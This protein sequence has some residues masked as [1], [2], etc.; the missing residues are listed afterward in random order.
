LP[1]TLRGAVEALIEHVQAPPSLCAHSVLSAA[2]LA[3]QGLA[4]V[5]IPNIP[6][7]RPLSLFML[8][9]AESGER[10]SACDDLLCRRRPTRRKAQS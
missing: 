2:A 5:K 4:N 9:I 1:D 10:K 7:P 6:R 3:A 8:A